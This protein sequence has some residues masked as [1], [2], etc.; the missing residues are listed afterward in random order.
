MEVLDLRG[1][2]CPVPVVETKKVI[3]RGNVNEITVVVDDDAARENVKRF[4]QSQGYDVSAEPREGATYLRGSKT[5]GE[6]KGLK[7]KSKRIAVFISSET[8]GRGDDELGAILMKSF[9]YTL[10]EFDP[11]PWR[12]IFI[13]GGVKLAAQG[14]PH[15]DLLNEIATRGTEILSCGTCLDFFRLKEKLGAGRITNMYDII[16]SLAEASVVIKP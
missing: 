3:D 4:L 8:V 16:A 1:K 2:R 11:A 5:V 7:G 12:I 14:S 9:L 10:K 6:E 15:L 13:N